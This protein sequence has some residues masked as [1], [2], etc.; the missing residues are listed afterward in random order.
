MSADPREQIREKVRKR[1]QELEAQVESAV[2]ALKNAK[3]ELR[4]FRLNECGHP[5]KRAYAPSA[6]SD[7]GDGV[8]S[9]LMICD[10]CGDR[11]YRD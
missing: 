8:L 11:W 6:M 4:K 2:E 10:D 3:D 9:G 5:D 7:P 1:R